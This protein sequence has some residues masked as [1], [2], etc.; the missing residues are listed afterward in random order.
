MRVASCIYLLSALAIL[1]IAV[2]GAF[3][4]GVGW[5]T[6]LLPIF[7]SSFLIQAHALFR[8]HPHAEYYAIFVSGALVLCSGYIAASLVAPRGPLSLSEALQIVWPVFTVAV[9]VAASHLLAV[10]LLVFRLARPNY[11]LKRTAANRHGVN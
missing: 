6:L 9:V 2:V 5:G 7:A 10:L 1:G 11:S 3:S 8:N 4:N